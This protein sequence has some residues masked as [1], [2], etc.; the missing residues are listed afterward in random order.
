MVRC[1]SSYHLPAFFLQQYDRIYTRHPSIASTDL[2]CVFFVQDLQFVCVVFHFQDD[3]GAIITP[4]GQS[5]WLGIYGALIARSTHKPVLVK[6][7]GAH[8]LLHSQLTVAAQFLIAQIPHLI[9]AQLVQYSRSQ[10]EQKWW[11]T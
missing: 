10:T 4:N 11:S 1:V 3:V 2:K 7:L 8:V 6:V 9:G 5:I